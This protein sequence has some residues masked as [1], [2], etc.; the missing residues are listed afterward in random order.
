[1]VF[2]GFLHQQKNLPPRYTCILNIVG[3]G[4]KHH[5]PNGSGEN[6]VILKFQNHL[7][8]L[9]KIF[10]WFVTNTAKVIYLQVWNVIIR[11]NGAV[12]EIDTITVV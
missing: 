3:S 6:W 12:L 1:M 11:S 7:V 8:V 5:N 2:P 10:K 4:V 9:K